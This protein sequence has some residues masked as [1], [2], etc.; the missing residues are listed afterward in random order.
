MSI[1][2]TLIA[3]IPRL[4]VVFRRDRAAAQP[5]QVAAPVRIAAL[6]RHGLQR[7]RRSSCQIGVSFGRR[8][9]VRSTALW[10]PHP[11]I[12]LPDSDNR[13]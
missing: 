9:I 5:H 2:I 7:I 8:M 10:V 13:R 12:S 11:R 3:G 1:A 6:F 4:A